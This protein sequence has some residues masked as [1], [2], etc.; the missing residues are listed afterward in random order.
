M[1]KVGLQHN[2]DI[3][4]LESIVNALDSSDVECD[5]YSRL[6]STVL[7]HLGV[8]HKV[9]VGRLDGPLG[10]IPWHVWI[11]IGDRICDCRV[12]MWLGEGGLHGLFVPPADW[13][14]DGEEIHFEALPPG[15]FELLAGHSL[16]AHLL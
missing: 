4:R 2:I 5:G 13:R 3:R 6:M 16:S 8:P 15:V 11:V 12:R 1:V 10:S 9:M 14:Y 7:Q